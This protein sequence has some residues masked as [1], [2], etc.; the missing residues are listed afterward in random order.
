[1]IRTFKNEIGCE[2]SFEDTIS[3]EQ[4]KE[5]LKWF[6]DSWKEVEQNGK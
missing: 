3:D 2:M 6:G 5:R 4:I 1:M